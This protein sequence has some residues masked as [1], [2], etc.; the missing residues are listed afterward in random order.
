M[1]DL[2]YEEDSQADVDMNVVMTGEGRI[3]EIQGTAEG[4]PFS[5]DQ[6]EGLMGLAKKGIEVLIEKQREALSD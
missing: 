6:M 3:I 5:Q 2:N 1:L 4:D